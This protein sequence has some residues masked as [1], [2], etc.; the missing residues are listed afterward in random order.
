MAETSPQAPRR[1]V[2]RFLRVALFLSLALNLAFVGLV[3][4]Q[5]WKAQDGRRPD[6]VADLGLGP[7]ARALSPAERADL[8]RDLRRGGGD[9]RRDRRANAE[10]LLA[11]IRAEPF[12]PEAVIA[13]LSEQRDRRLAEQARAQRVFAERLAAMSPERRAEFAAALAADLR[14]GPP[15]QAPTRP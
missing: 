7:V 12:D 1:G 6:A 2:S 13:L 8:G 4:G 9:A 10:A 3:A 15:P 5:V 11:A 14:R